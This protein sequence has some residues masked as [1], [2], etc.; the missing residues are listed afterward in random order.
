MNDRLRVAIQ[1]ALDSEGEAQWRHVGATGWG[2]AWSLALDGRRYFVKLASA[3]RADMLEAE[4]DGLQAIAHTRT[5]R[6]PG[7]IAAGRD[8]RDAYLVIEWLDM[9]G[10]TDNAALG[11]ALAQMHRAPT[12]HGRRGGRFGWHRDNRIGATAQSNAWSDDWCAFF[13]ERRLA[14]QFALASA[15]GF[16]GALQRN[17]ERL[18]ARLPSLLRDHDV[19]PSVVHGD[20]WS[21]NA[22][23][24]ADGTGVVFDPA[25]YVGDREVD[26]AMTEL[27]GGFGAT[28]AHAYAD[29]WPLDARYPL[30]RGIYNLYHL[31]NHLNLFGASYLPRV[32][33]SVA[34]IL[35]AGQG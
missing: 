34:Q 12:P 35:A 29:A 4:A 13:G 7:V 33:R 30:R 19:V 20:L 6:V 10:R 2:D 26:I 25:V 24:L 9:T 16:G 3:E 1:R 18:L 14:P 17:G 5:V 32:E 27:F 22:A 31:L 28:F 8:D 23:T 11:V 15:N 21:G